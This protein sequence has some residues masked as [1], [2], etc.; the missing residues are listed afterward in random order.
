MSTAPFAGKNR[1][2]RRA[3][4][5]GH[6]YKPRGLPCNIA[7]E[8]KIWTVCGGYKGGGG[9]IL[10][11]CYDEADAKQ[12]LEYMLPFPQFVGL[13]ISA[14][15]DPKNPMQIFNAELRANAEKRNAA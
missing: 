7:P 5:F 9:G 15:N 13:S 1:R 6:G 11:W 14:Y 4:Q 10:E 3:E 12:M 8:D 2:Q